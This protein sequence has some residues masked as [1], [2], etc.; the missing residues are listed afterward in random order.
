MAVDSGA[1]VHALVNVTDPTFSAC[2]PVSP[3]ISEALALQG[4]V[5]ARTSSASIVALTIFGGVYTEAFTTF[6]AMCG[7]SGGIWH[8]LGLALDVPAFT[9]TA[10]GALLH[11][12]PGTKCSS[13]YSAGLA[14]YGRSGTSQSTQRIG[15]I[16]G[17]PW[18]SIGRVQLIA[19]VMLV[20]ANVSVLMIEMDVILLRP[21]L[22]AIWREERSAHTAGHTARKWDGASMHCSQSAW[23]NRY[24]LGLQ[25][26]WASSAETNLDFLSAVTVKTLRARNWNQQQFNIEL[27]CRQHDKQP[28]ASDSCPGPVP[29]LLKLPMCEKPLNPLHRL[30]SEQYSLPDLT[31]RVL[32]L[33]D[34]RKAAAETQLVA[35]HCVGGGDGAAKLSR[36][37]NALLLDRYPARLH[38]G[39]NKRSGYVFIISPDLGDSLW[40][41]TSAALLRDTVIL[42]FL[43]GDAL[44]RTPLLLTHPPLRDALMHGSNEGSNTTVL[45]K[46]AQVNEDC[47]S[48]RLLSNCTGFLH[49]AFLRGHL[50]LNRSAVPRWE[51]ATWR[52]GWEQ[53]RRDLEMDL[54]R[55]SSDDVD[56]SRDEAVVAR[57]PDSLLVVDLLPY[58]AM[59]TVPTL[60][61]ALAPNQPP[62]PAWSN[63]LAHGMRSLHADQVKANMLR[64]VWRCVRRELFIVPGVRHSLLKHCPK[65]YLGAL[66]PSWYQVT[67]GQAG[68]KGR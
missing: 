32:R 33:N 15:G 38:A 6:C 54:E 4:A 65:G 46:W 19:L 8:V 39:S 3:S 16:A 56:V 2:A 5:R 21:L 43:L 22:P 58:N 25:L 51:S 47:W 30:W 20:Q 61:E 9:A 50:F 18:Y 24:N 62:S 11:A 26:W 13:L 41:A 59:S 31:D 52:R 68:S 17:A 40:N 45:P 36:F 14:E 60:D 37:S 10:A 42:T 34:V 28:G 48:M 67:K 55:A 29:T 23:A 53:I 7:K 57:A 1:C 49:A 63:A 27:L 66:E 12:L 35:M 44:R 64:D